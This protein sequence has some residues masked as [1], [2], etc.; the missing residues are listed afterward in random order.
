V[1][2]LLASPLGLLIGLSLGALGGGG[3]I[4]AVPALVY[5]AGETA[6]V[7]TSTSLMVVGAASLMGVGSHWRAGRVRWGHGLLFGITG[8]GGSAVGT[9]ANKAVDPDVLL[10][11]FSGVMVL[12]AAAMWRRNRGDAEVGPPSAENVPV[13]DQGTDQGANAG[14]RGVAPA[15]D[16]LTW[17][18]LPKVLLAGTAVGLMTGFFG[19]GGGFVIVPA[20]VL[21]MGF[22]MPDAVG[23]SLVVIAINSAMALGLRAGSLDI[24]WGDALPFLAMAIIGTVLGKRIA[25]RV[26]AAKLTTGFVVLL[27][28]I[29]AYTAVSSVAQLV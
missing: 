14:A 26:P 3:S 7:A 11:A 29:A 15:P 21:T 2:G 24:H 16:A 4:L 1:R 10:L 22:S 20:L 13:D 6:Q 19:V 25:D 23:T 9:A 27:F 8:I 18:A 12:A 5:G 17:G 28:A